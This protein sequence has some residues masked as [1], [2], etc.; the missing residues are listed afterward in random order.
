MPVL[1][2]VRRGTSGE[3]GKIKYEMYIFLVQECRTP[4]RTAAS[5]LLASHVGCEKLRRKR[6]FETVVD[7]GAEDSGAFPCSEVTQ[8]KRHDFLGGGGGGGQIHARNE[9]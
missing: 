7:D 6:I 1:G 9:A 2:I 3:Q 5:S 4:Y 8:R